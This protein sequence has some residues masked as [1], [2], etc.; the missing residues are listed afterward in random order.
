MFW[1]NGKRPISVD[2]R[3]CFPHAEDELMIMGAII[4]I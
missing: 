2:F 3:G 1:K 4:E